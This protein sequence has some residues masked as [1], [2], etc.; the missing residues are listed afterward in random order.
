MSNWRVDVYNGSND[1]IHT[2]VIWN[3]TEDEAVDE[4]EA[5]VG[6]CDGGVDDWTLTQITDENTASKTL[7]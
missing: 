6:R 3:R 2:W 5:D 7:K 1:I 4:A